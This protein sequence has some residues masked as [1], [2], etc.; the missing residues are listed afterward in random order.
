MLIILK[1]ELSSLFLSPVAYITTA[2]F[3]AASSWVFLQA[4]E[5][6]EGE[7]ASVVMLLMVS[8]MIWLP[9]LI[10]VVSMRLFSEE[11]RSGTL[12]A[13]M[14]VAVSDV[15]VVLGKYFSALIFV[16]LA[17]VPAVGSIYWFAYISPG[18]DGVDVFA[19]AGGCVILALVSMSCVAIGLL[20]SLLTRNQ[21]VAAISCF[22]AICVPFLIKSVVVVVPFVTD[23]VV[24]Y[25]S[26]ENHLLSFAAGTLSLP[27]FVL[28][29]SESVLL[30]FAAVRVLE[31]R[32]WL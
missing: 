30:L 32:R 31:A 16:W 26:L 21:I 12:E 9:I 2:V 10:T 14:T 28:Y 15:S 29:L 13:L 8:V 11:K 19:L 22:A 6:N 3:T 20:V 27:V 24:Q 5:A 4:V 23:S 18:I 1:K 17:L 25:L 7:D